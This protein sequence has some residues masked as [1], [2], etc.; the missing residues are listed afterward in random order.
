MQWHDRIGRRLKLRDLHILLA[1]VQRGSMAKAAAELAISQPAVSK[2]I[3]DMEYAVGQR[4]L[5]RSRRGIEPTTFGRVLVKRGTAIFDE[6]KQAAQELDFLTDPTVGELR[7]GSS[8][9]MAAGLLPAIIDRFS[10]LYPRVALTVAQAVFATMQ[11]RE[12]RER[13]VDLLLGRSYAPFAEADL[14][15]EVLFDDPSVVLAGS[16]SRWAKSRRL[17]LA[18]LS[19]E[20]WILPPAD[21]LPR[22]ATAEMFRASGVNLPDAPL[23]TLS[24]HVVLQLVATGRFVTILPRSVLRFSGRDRRL[25]ELPIKLPILPRPIVIMS[26][27]N[28]ALSPIAQRFIDCARAVAKNG[29]L[30]KI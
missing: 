20:R 8:E 6:L 13:S 27:K 17:R 3:A 30:K 14:E 18:D 11:Y 21:S 15:S 26:L 9:G 25:K 23:T 19:H 5:D 16:R 2:A 10:R 22:A 1:V 29:G 28:R 12:L 24:I 7:V 4:L